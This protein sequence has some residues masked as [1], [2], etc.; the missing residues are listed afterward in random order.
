MFRNIAALKLNR[1]PGVVLVKEALFIEA[2]MLKS[3]SHLPK[4]FLIIC[5]NESLL[6][7]IKNVFY[8]ILKALFVFKIFK[9]LS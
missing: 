5:F 1:D 8:F 6:K 7:M 3:D 2:L 9:F 4:K